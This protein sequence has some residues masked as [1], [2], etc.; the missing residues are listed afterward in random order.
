MGELERCIASVTRLESI[1]CVLIAE[2]TILSSS[3]NSDDR[4]WKDA[5][6][7]SWSIGDVKDPSSFFVNLNVTDMFYH[8]SLGGMV[9]NLG[10]LDRTDSFVTDV[11][12]GGKGCE[13]IACLITLFVPVAMRRKRHAT[14]MIDFIERRVNAE[15]NM[16]LVVG[17][18]TDETDAMKTILHRKGYRFI[19]PF[20]YIQPSPLFFA[21]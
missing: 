19:P 8:D 4:L 13:R 9:L 11:L 7:K 2:Y 14:R 21:S 16:R 20:C 17:P 6:T 3:S 1:H 12:L 10:L 18:I 15:L 5:L